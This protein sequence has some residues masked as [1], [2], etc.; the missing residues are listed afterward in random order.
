MWFSTPLT[1][2]FSAHGVVCAWLVRILLKQVRLFL[3]LWRGLFALRAPS[4]LRPVCFGLILLLTRSE[5]CCWD[6]W[7]GP[8]SSS[9]PLVWGEPVVLSRPL[10]RQL[11]SSGRWRIAL[12]LPSTSPVWPAV[13]QASQL[14]LALSTR[15]STCEHCQQR[16][17]GELLVETCRLKLFSCWG[18]REFPASVALL[19]WC[20]WGG[21]PAGRLR[22]SQPL[23]CPQPLLCG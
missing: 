16:R 14:G 9:R 3:A 10:C 1:V 15:E 7:W 5:L 12:W 8:A 17:K 19:V 20:V 21:L 18:R 23:A 22:S 2:S 13:G 11:S 4:A 6:L